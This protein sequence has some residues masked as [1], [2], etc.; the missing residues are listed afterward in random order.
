MDTHRLQAGDVIWLPGGV[1]AKLLGD[2]AVVEQ[3]IVR[4]TAD[5]LRAQHER[6][7]VRG[8]HPQEK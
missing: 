7:R 6:T 3:A 4:L 2:V 1:P 5:E 8:E